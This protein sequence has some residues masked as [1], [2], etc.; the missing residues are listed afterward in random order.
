M[1]KITK[2]EKLWVFMASKNEGGLSAYI[3][4]IQCEYVID[5]CAMSLE[6]L[7]HGVRSEIWT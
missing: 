3:E 2:K 5:D 6:F 7:D 1:N 4:E